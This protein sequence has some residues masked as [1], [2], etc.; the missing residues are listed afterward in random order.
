MVISDALNLDCGMGE[1]DHGTGMTDVCG[2]RPHSS[3]TLDPTYGAHSNLTRT[4]SSSCPDFDQYDIDGNL[5]LQSASRTDG[6]RNAMKRRERDCGKVDYSSSSGTSGIEI[7]SQSNRM[8]TMKNVLFTD[9]SN[10]SPETIS[11]AE[12]TSGDDQYS[13]HS[14]VHRQQFSHPLKFSP[15]SIRDTFK[16]GHVS[17]SRTHSFKN[18]IERGPSG[19]SGI[20]NP[21]Q[22]RHDNSSTSLDLSGPRIEDLLPHES[23]LI[24]VG[25]YT[26]KNRVNLKHSSFRS[27]Y[28][29]RDQIHVP[30]QGNWNS[31]KEQTRDDQYTSQK[32]NTFGQD[33]IDQIETISDPKGYNYSFSNGRNL[34]TQNYDR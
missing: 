15:Q 8:E 30:Y 7:V 34:S 24:K 32:Y 5:C 9:N 29:D 18:A 23:D 22:D 31:H 25:L 12:D 4:N 6:R 20:S 10:C 19:D 26:D 16:F 14:P 17:R 28:Y 3:N 1:G 13:K 21:S 11:G 33:Y 2:Q 27:G